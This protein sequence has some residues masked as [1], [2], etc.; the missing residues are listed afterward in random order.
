MSRNREK[1]CWGA[2][3]R[4]RGEWSVAA[5]IPLP[6]RIRQAVSTTKITAKVYQVGALS[7]PITPFVFVTQD[8][9]TDALRGETVGGGAT[10]RMRSDAG[11][12]EDLKDENPFDPSI[13]SQGGKQSGARP[14]GLPG[15]LLFLSL[16]TAGSRQ[17]IPRPRP[18]PDQ[19][20]NLVVRSRHHNRRRGGNARV[21]GEY[22]N[23][24]RING[25]SDYWRHE[26]NEGAVVRRAVANHVRTVRV[27]GEDANSGPFC[28]L[29]RDRG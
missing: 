8:G 22:C 11:I 5:P 18:E 2:I 3:W 23:R 25:N 17:T 24:W 20:P 12:T 29:G 7:R 28:G 27:A 4:R 16:T 6:R 21:S 15:L 9:A 10:G 13:R 19:L 26:R 1:H 14:T